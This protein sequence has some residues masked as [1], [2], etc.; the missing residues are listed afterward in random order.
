MMQ[1]LF[2]LKAAWDLIDWMKVLKAWIALSL[3]IN[4]II[5]RVWRVPAEAAPAW[6]DWCAAHPRRAGWVKL[7]RGAGGDAIKTYV[8]AM[9]I[10]TARKQYDPSSTFPP[11][12][13]DGG[14]E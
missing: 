9:M 13:R 6:K 12:N 7:F 2:V 3:V 14:L 1:T 11:E 4:F 10:V 5:D 8:A